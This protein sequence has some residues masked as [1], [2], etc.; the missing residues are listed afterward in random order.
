MC[1]LRYQVTKKRI[2]ITLLLSLLAL[3]IVGFSLDVFIDS[4]TNSFNQSGMGLIV[5]LLI[6][7]CYAQSVEVEAL[8]L[9]YTKM[10]FPFLV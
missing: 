6:L 2:L 4:E 7:G 5:L 1:R 10:K 3:L 9:C 8:G